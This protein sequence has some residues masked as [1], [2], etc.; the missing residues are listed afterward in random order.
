MSE[1]INLKRQELVDAIRD[2]IKT[3]I[4]NVM[5]NDF[6][7]FL[8]NSNFIRDDLLGKFFGE[9]ILS[10]IKEYRKFM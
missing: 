6:N 10:L 9:N 4:N 2:E 7:G 1:N 5:D 8:N 3:S